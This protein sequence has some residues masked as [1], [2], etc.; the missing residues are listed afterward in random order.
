LLLG[1][2]VFGLLGSISQVALQQLGLRRPTVIAELK[3]QLLPPA[4]ELIPQYQELSS[5]PAIDYDLNFVVNESVRWA[6]LANT[7]TQAAGPVLERIEYRETYRDPQRDGAGRKRLLLSVRLRSADQTLTGEQA[8]A[9]RQ[10]II[11]A[12][13]QTHAATLL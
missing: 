4:A 1:N 10:A 6:D 2:E 5:Y 3:L 13:Q 9:T 12:C 11:A 7:V 8:D